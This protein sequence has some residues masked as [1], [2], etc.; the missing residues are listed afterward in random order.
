MSWL[1]GHGKRR[2]GEHNAILQQ[3]NAGL[4]R[5]VTWYRNR[6]HETVAQLRTQRARADIAEGLLAAA[7]LRISELESASALTQ[8]LPALKVV[9]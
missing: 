2:A 7:Q 6:L 3:E 5:R 1:K 8:K 9:A 4:R